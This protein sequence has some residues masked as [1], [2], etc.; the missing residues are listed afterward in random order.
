MI[1]SELLLSVYMEDTRDN[2]Q[3]KI[4]YFLSSLKNNFLKTNGR[5][6][7][8]YGRWRYESFITER[9]AQTSCVFFKYVKSKICKFLLECVQL[10][11]GE[12]AVSPLLRPRNCCHLKC[13]RCSRSKEEKKKRK[14]KTKN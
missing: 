7:R 6:I 13:S 4:R 9:N 1:V 8:V 12:T 2:E 5:F 3:T 10:F 14:K 11:Q